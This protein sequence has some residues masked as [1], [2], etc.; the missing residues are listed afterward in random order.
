MAM[1]NLRT[2]CYALGSIKNKWLELGISFGIPRNKLEE[3]EEK[4]DPFSAVIDY[5]LKGNITD[6]PPPISWQFIVEALK[7]EYVGEPG[8]GSQIHK[9]YIEDVAGQT[10]QAMVHYL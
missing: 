1:L 5:Y 9:K 10:Q 4:R 2:V 8:L 7:S 3:F 6:P